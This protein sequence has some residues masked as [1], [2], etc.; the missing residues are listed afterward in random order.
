M[1]V[2]L[3]GCLLSVL[4]AFASIENYTPIERQ[5]IKDGKSYLAIREFTNDGDSYFLGVD[6]ESLETFIF[7]TKETKDDVIGSYKSSRYG[8]LLQKY[9]APPYPLQNDGLAHVDDVQNMVFLTS[10]LCPSSKHGYEQQFYAHLAD[11]QNSS[12]FPVAIAVSGKWIQMH[13]QEFEQLQQYK[14]QKK[15]NILWVNHSFSHPYVAGIPLKRNFLLLPGVDF[16]REVL[17]LEKLLL[18]HGEMPSV[19][20][21]FPGLVSDESLIKKLETL[22]LIPLGSDAWLAKGQQVKSGS[23]I[24]VHGNGNEHSGIERFEKLFVEQNSSFMF[25]DLRKWAE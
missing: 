24:L 11:N 6:T 18:E 3:L 16:E 15:L 7:K 9:T 20:F 19:F 22:H 5:I 10:D 4:S 12:R 8:K 13:K 21:R 25:G 1:K 23:I 14:K 2:I 17:E